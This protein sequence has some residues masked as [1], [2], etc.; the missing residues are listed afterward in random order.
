MLISK[1]VYLCAKFLKN[2]VNPID[3]EE[4]SDANITGMN[5]SRVAAQWNFLCALRIIPATHFRDDD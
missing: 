4:Q 2:W 5:W 3:C 1:I